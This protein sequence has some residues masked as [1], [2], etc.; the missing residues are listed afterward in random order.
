M[1]LSGNKIKLVQR[2]PQN[3][4]YKSQQNMPALLDHLTWHPSSNTLLSATWSREGR[5]K[6]TKKDGPRNPC[7]RHP[8]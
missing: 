5:K 7:H 8:F 4:T 3:I 2:L 1:D 6:C